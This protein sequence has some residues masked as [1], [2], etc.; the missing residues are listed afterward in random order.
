[1]TDVALVYDKSTL[2][3]IMV[4]VPD[5]EGQL[6]EAAFNPPGSAQTRVTQAQYST[7]GPDDIA[8]AVVQ[9]ASK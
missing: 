8:A 6:D 1:M 7:M 4:V 5:H 9:A 3:L 2:A